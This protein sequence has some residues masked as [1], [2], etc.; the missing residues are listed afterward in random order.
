MKLLIEIP[1]EQYI[2]TKVMVQ[3]HNI[4]SSN[5]RVIANGIPLPEHHGR[6]IEIPY[7]ATNGDVIKALFYVKDIEELECCTFASIAG[8]ADM[9]VYKDWWN[10]PYKAESESEE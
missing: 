2:A 9:R 1:E 10:A 7:N 3:S 6:L 5:D 4:G 8:D